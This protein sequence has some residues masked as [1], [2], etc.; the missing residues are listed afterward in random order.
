[1]KFYVGSSFKNNQLVNYISK[2][3]SKF[4]WENTHNWA[5]NIKVNE[6]QSDLISSSIQ[7]KEAIKSADV[8]IIVLPGGLGTHIEI[9]MALAWEKKVY[10][11][12]TDEKLLNGTVNFYYLPDIIKL[13]GNIDDIIQKIIKLEG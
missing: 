12:S 13:S 8:I 4:D 10:L 5:E 11:C 7:E 3:F 9:G 1:M 2:E 6:T